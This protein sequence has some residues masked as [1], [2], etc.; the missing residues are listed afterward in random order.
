MTKL[1][2][3]L[4]EFMRFSKHLDPCCPNIYTPGWFE[5][6]F[7]VVTQRSFFWHEF[8]IKVSVS[9]YRAD[10]RKGNDSRRQKYEGPYPNWYYCPWSEPKHATL[11]RK[12][13]P[14]PNYFWFVMPEA[15]AFKVKIPKYAGLLIHRDEKARHLKIKI[16]KPAPRRHREKVSTR[17]MSGMSRIEKHGVNDGKS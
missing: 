6:D 11:A 16:A 9:D 1:E 12:A 17:F 8:E 4:L 7:A 3:D 13:T 5:S 15:I 10:F 2:T 14:G